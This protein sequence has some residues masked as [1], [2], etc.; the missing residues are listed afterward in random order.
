MKNR[1]STP[2]KISVQQVEDSDQT[3]YRD[4]TPQSIF[5]ISTT[6][7]RANFELEK[8]RQEQ[9][10]QERQSEENMITENGSVSNIEKPNTSIANETSTPKLNNDDL[11]VQPS[12]DVPQKQRSRSNSLMQSIEKREKL[13]SKDATGSA[14]GGKNL[15]ITRGATSTE[16]ILRSAVTAQ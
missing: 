15:A 13:L 1:S 8:M 2:K 3:A 16:D 12:L 11:F 5:K 7:E 4:T 14:S 9:N 10:I 6:N